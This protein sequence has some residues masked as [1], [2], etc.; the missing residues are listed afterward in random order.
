MRAIC[1]C[2]DVTSHDINNLYYCENSVVY[3]KKNRRLSIDF[4]HQS[5]NFVINHCLLS[6]I[7]GGGDPSAPPPP[8]QITCEYD[9]FKPF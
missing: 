3:T 4:E 9:I 7:G 2:Y 5:H 6:Q 8:L 1:T